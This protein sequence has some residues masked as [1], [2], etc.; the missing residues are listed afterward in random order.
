MEASLSRRGWSTMLSAAEIRPAKMA[1]GISDL[2]VSGDL[3]KSSF[4]GLTGKETR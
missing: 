2:E 1:Q 4:A 3:S